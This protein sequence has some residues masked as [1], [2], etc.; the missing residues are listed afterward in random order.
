MSDL[1][2][3]VVGICVM[4][5]IT[6]YLIVLE[7]YSTKNRVLGKTIYDYIKAANEFEQLNTLYSIPYWW[8]N[9]LKCKAEEIRRRNLVW[10]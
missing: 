4:I 2:W 5:V 1:N 3:I 7:Y 6:L 9:E 10:K 8:R